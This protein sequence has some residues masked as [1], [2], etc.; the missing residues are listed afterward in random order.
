[1]TCL[2]GTSSARAQD[3]QQQNESREARERREK[4][5]HAEMARQELVNLEKE[6]VHAILNGNTAF[7][8]RVYSDDF[9]AS[10]PSGQILDKSTY[11]K[12]VQQAPV[13]YTVFLATDINVR[14]YEDTAVVTSM[15]T[16]HGVLEGRAVDR[17]WR[18]THVYVT[19]SQGWRAVLS[20]ET[21]LPH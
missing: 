18:V 13:K 21:L 15:W 19:T 11:I 17:Q 5:A 9:L 2:F 7:F 8:N 3:E 12:A 20:H 14:I 6:T 16:S 10:T 1:M 4:A